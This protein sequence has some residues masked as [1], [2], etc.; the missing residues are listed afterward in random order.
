MINLHSEVNERLELRITADLLGE[1]RPELAAFLGNVNVGHLL[2]E[3]FLPLSQT[4][5]TKA[6]VAY[7]ERPWP[8]AGVGARALRGLALVVI[9]DDGQSLLTP[10]MLSAQHNTNVG[11]AAG[12]TKLLFED[13]AAGGAE[14]VAY[15]VN[16]HSTVVSGELT[17]VGFEPRAARVLTAET[18]FVAYAAKPGVVLERL[19]LADARLGDVLAMNLDRASASRLTSFHLSL[20]AGVSNYWADRTRWAEVFPGF[21]DWAS[22]PPGGITGTP[23]PAIDPTDPLI[24]VER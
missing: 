23:G 18:E 15:F 6:A 24:I 8:P 17:D 5:R 1:F 19:G 20:S 21:I 12:L 14:W 3:V 2:E 10:V 22:L 9:S 16:Q 13:L 4:T 7:E 11:L